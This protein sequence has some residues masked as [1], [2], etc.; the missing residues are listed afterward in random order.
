MTDSLSS[1]DNDSADGIPER[2][3]HSRQRELVQGLL[4]AVADRAHAEEALANDQA[5]WS[6]TEGRGY[7]DACRALEQKRDDARATIIRQYDLV[8][9]ETLS[10]IDAEISAIQ[11]EYDDRVA[12]LQQK[13]E[14]DREQIEKE[15][16]EARWMVQAV[17]DDTAED[18]PKHKFETYKASLK[19]SR[20]RRLADWEDLAGRVEAVA[21][22]LAGWRMSQ[23][24]STSQGKRPP[25]DTDDCLE[26]FVECVDEAN[27]DIDAI[28]RQ[29]LP[30]LFGGGFPLVL[31]GLL[32]SLVAV[33][34]IVLDV[35]GKLKLVRDANSLGPSVG[36]S[37]GASLV[38][39][40][41]MMGLVLLVARIRCR[42]CRRR[43]S[44]K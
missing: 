8:H 19:V 28:G 13:S 1:T 6:E 12:E 18:S 44:C 22:Q 35:P 3:E 16:E 23:S 15:R 38:A 40:M 4:Q 41:M 36:I 11:I 26:H 43:K 27:H 24:P 17:L 25:A 29:W 21:G 7:E 34:L 39:A 42:R 37:I 2:L 30:R 31:W 14:G 9:D 33:P 20:V 10:Q 32:S 5:G